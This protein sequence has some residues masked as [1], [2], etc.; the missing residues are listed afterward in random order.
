M[1]N[2]AASLLVAVA[3]LAATNSHAA[4][5]RVALIDESGVIIKPDGLVIGIEIG[6]APVFTTP[7]PAHHEQRVVGPV[8]CPR[9]VV[10]PIKNLFDLSCASEQA[11]RQAAVTN[12]QD[13]AY[14][15]QRCEDLAAA[16]RSAR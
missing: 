8:A 6:D 13:V 9:E 4:C 3:I 2:L 1:K 11:M 14:V 10:D 5:V 15:L 12:G 7:L 16:I